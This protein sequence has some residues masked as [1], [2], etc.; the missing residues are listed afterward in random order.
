MIAENNDGRNRNRPQ[1]KKAGVKVPKGG[2]SRKVPHSPDQ[3]LL[4]KRSVQYHTTLAQNV[5][6]L[7]MAAGLSQL[8]V[9]ERL[10][11]DR[12]T[13]I[14]IETGKT[15]PSFAQACV[16]AE[17]FGV[18][19]DSLSKDLSWMYAMNNAGSLTDALRTIR[20]AENLSQEDVASQCGI[21]RTEYG[22]I[23][24]GKKQADATML[25]K[26]SK[27]LGRPIVF[28]EAG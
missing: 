25:A 5:R 6:I 12:T 27:V 26:L 20:L 2:D 9:A 22:L 14:R 10:G 8:A 7:R 17:I 1:R 24:S 11:W 28:G 18:P 13:I 21:S 4:L 16:I 15:C 3:R 19:V 23:E